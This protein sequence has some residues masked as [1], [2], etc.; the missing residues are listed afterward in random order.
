MEQAVNRF[1]DLTEKQGR[2]SFGQI[3][4]SAGN[5][6]AE[7]LKRLWENHQIYGVSSRRKDD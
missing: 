2:Q 1:N 3:M 6:R 4:E 5:D 7:K